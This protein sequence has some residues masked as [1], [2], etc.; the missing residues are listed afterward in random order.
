LNIFIRSG[1]FRRQT[2]K[3]TEIWPNFA[4]FWPLKFFWGGSLKILDWDY[5]T[6]RGTEHRAKFRADRPTELGDYARKKRKNHSKTEVLPKTIVFGRTKKQ[7]NLRLPLNIQ[8]PDVFEL[9]GCF[10]L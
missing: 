9:Q 3:S 2:S 7:A 5:K 6:E 8:K 4:C 1:D 10:A